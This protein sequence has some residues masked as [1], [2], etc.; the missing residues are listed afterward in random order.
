MELTRETFSEQLNTPFHFLHEAHG[1]VE[2]TLT[3][4]ADGILREGRGLDL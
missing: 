3:E 1:R 4:A 2:T